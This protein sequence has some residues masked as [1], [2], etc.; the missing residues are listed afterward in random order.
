[1][2]NSPVFIAPRLCGERRRHVGDL[3][4]GN[5]NPLT[6]KLRDPKARP[7][8]HGHFSLAPG[9]ILRGYGHWPWEGKR[10]ELELRP[11]R[12]ALNSRLVKREPESARQLR[13]GPFNFVPA[14]RAQV[15]AER[16]KPQPGRLWEN[17]GAA[18]LKAVI[19]A[20]QP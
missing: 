10:L 8:D 7:E 12:S 19:G 5:W 13:P 4:I 16:V 17:R 20:D 11:V 9:G 1:M 15:A 6:I 2:R 14:Q 18:R 3:G